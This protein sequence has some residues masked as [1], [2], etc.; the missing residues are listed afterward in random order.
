MKKLSLREVHCLRSHNYSLTNLRFRP[1]LPPEL[2]IH[3]D[4][5]LP[6]SGGRELHCFV[7]K[8]GSMILEFLLA[9]APFHFI[10]NILNVPIFCIKENYAQVELQV[11]N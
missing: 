9:K 5:V 10:A 6:P 8:I 7:F 11:T 2:R 1:N 3:H 4:L